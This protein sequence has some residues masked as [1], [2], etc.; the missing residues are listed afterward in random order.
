MNKFPEPKFKITRHHLRDGAKRK[1]HKI[2]SKQGIDFSP[3]GGQSA[4][5]FIHRIE[6]N[7]WAAVELAGHRLPAPSKMKTSYESIRHRLLAVPKNERRILNL[8]LK[9][10]AGDRISYEQFI[11]DWFD[12]TQSQ[13]GSPAHKHWPVNLHF[14]YNLILDFQMVFQ[15]PASSTPDG[16]FDLIL[17]ET[18]KDASPDFKKKPRSLKRAI[19]R[20]LKAAKEY[21]TGDWYDQFLAD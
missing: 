18:L 11:N 17:Q 6:T 7:L 8:S 10:V 3:E 21:P 19:Q 16:T 9:E 14:I 1:I 4:D 5:F 15:R 13:I 2:I 20:C 12:N